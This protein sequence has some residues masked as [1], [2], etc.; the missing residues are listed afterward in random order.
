MCLGYVHILLYVVSIILLTKAALCVVGYSKMQ[1]V[2]YGHIAECIIIQTTQWADFPCVGRQG[3][4]VE[5]K[6]KKFKPNLGMAY[7][8]FSKKQTNKGI[9]LVALEDV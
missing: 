4:S 5:R 8:Y 3:N 9:S 6:I 1:R 2:L 7:T